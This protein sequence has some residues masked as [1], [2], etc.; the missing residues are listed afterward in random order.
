LI[1]VRLD[2]WLRWVVPIDQRPVN[3]IVGQER[4]RKF[5]GTEADLAMFSWGASR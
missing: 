4:S 3:S 5:E 1:V 2:H